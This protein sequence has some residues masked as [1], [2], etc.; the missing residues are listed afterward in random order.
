MF[1]SYGT[2]LSPIC[3][4]DFILIDWHWLLW[5]DGLEKYNPN[6]SILMFLYGQFL[7]VPEPHYLISEHTKTVVYHYHK[8]CRLNRSTALSKLTQ[9]AV[10]SN[11]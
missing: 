4:D 8:L 2:F 3:S 5:H 11:V 9:T 6:A 7:R 10:F 1:A